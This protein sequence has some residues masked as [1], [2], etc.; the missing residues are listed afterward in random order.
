[1][2]LTETPVD[3]TGGSLRE[4]KSRTGIDHLIQFIATLN[5]SNKARNSSIFTDF[6]KNWIMSEAARGMTDLFVLGIF[7]RRHP[8]EFKNKKRKL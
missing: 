2:I 4:Y 8:F 3:R 1:V 7:K 6:Q 5:G